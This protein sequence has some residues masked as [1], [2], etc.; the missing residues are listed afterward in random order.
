MSLVTS[1]SFD[2]LFYKHM[3]ENEPIV[4]DW[5]YDS[6]N[7]KII[8]EKNI[9]ETKKHSIVVSTDILMKQWIDRIKPFNLS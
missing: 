9:N 1:V 8:F 6:L 3:Y 7:N 5:K 2:K 4:Y